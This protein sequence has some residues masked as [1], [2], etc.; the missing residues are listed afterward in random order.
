[1][2]IFLYFFVGNFGNYLIIIVKSRFAKICFVANLYFVVF[3]WI[4]TNRV[5][6][7]GLQVNLAMMDFV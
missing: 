7:Q 1:M 4:A 2:W 5:A 3:F 6:M